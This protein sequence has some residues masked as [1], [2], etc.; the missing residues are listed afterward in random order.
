PTNISAG[1]PYVINEGQGLTLIATATDPDKDPLKYTWDLNGD[2]KFGDAVGATVTLTPAQ[3]AAL[4]LQDGTGIPKTIMLRV[5]DGVNLPVDEVAT[6]TIKD[7]APTVKLV[8]PATT[9][10][11]TRPT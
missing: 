5:K 2:G 1:G 3:M 11:G 7:V 9:P 10:Q 4:G 6:L 8:A